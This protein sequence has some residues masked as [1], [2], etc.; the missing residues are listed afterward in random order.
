VY[1]IRYDSGW[2][3]GMTRLEKGRDRIE[4]AFAWIGRNG[5]DMDILDS[6]NYTLV[7]SDRSGQVKTTSLSTTESIPV[8]SSTVEHI[9]SI[10]IHISLDLHLHLHLL[11]DKE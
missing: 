11:K 8:K 2:S 7:N 5:L 6:R 10:P 4:R 9:A 3:D 1:L